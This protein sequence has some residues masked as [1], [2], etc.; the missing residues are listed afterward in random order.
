M[1][2]S[3]PLTGPPPPGHVPVEHRWLGLDRRTIPLAAVVLGLMLVFMVAIPAIDDAV[4]WDDETRAGDVL[5]L[6]RGVTVVP[7][8]GWELT[9]GIRVGD[10]PASGITGDGA[11]SIGSGGVQ[12]TVTR[13]N[14]DGTP[15]ELLDQVNRL[16]TASDADGNRAFKVTGPRATVTTA[17]GLTGVSEAY[18]SASGEGRVLAFTL[19]AGTDGTTP[20]G[21]TITIDATD[22]AYANQSA[23]IGALIDSLTVEEPAS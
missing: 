11:A 6:G 19:D 16:R 15:D 21:V 9:S 3:E 5:D 22:T 12:L 10:E 18:T 20:T 17:S 4:G 13:G 23:A 14:F 2:A 8:T 1:E 7:P